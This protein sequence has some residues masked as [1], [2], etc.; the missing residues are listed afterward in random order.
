MG[1]VQEGYLRKRFGAWHLAYYIK[2]N[3]QSK[4]KSHRLCDDSQTKSQAKQ[5]RNEF[6]RTQ[7][8]VGEQNSGPI[9]VV[10]FWD[11]V[12]LPFIESSGSLKPATVWGYKQIWNQHLKSHFGTTHLSNYKTHMMSAFL[13]SLAKTHRPRTLNNIKWTAS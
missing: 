9:G 3:G 4:L 6:L 7:V 2:E 5:L 1:R 11:N 10:D 13:T 8:N 12:Y